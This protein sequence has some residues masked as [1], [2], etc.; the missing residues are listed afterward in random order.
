MKSKNYKPILWL[1]LIVLFAGL[2]SCKKEEHPWSDYLDFPPSFF[3]IGHDSL[4]TLNYSHENQSDTVALKGDVI[5]KAESK[6]DWIS[7]PGSNK[8]HSDLTLR[9]GE[10]KSQ[11]SREGTIILTSTSVDTLPPIAIQVIQGGSAPFM[12]PAKDSVALNS[13]SFTVEVEE[14]IEAYHIKTPW[15]I[16]VSDST[17]VSDFTT[18]YTF[19]VA[20]SYFADRRGAVVF[21]GKGDN[22]DLKDTV[23][24]KQ[25]KTAFPD[26]G[27][28]LP[29]ASLFDVA[30]TADSAKDYSPF[31]FTL[32]NG[33]LPDKPVLSFDSDLNRYVAS[34]DAGKKT[35]F[36]LDYAP[37]GTDFSDKFSDYFTLEVYFKPDL[38][39]T[40]V[41]TV[42]GS[43]KFGGMT[44]EYDKE[45]TLVMK[46]GS[47]DKGYYDYYTI[48]NTKLQ[49]GKYYHV[50]YT[51][52]YSA[53]NAKVYVNGTLEGEVDIDD[54][55][56]RLPYYGDDRWFGFG[57][58]ETA[59]G[60]GENF[61]SGDIVF[62][63][64]YSN[65]KTASD[66]QAM[67]GQIQDRK[68]LTGISDLNDAI[69]NVL[70]QKLADAGEDQKK[71]IQAAIT[72]GWKL[73]DNPGT[74]DEI[75]QTYLNN[76]EVLLNSL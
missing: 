67:Y 74:T 72:V 7:V 47:G 37:K 15:W 39:N 46:L 71:P 40:G 58:D 17:P 9:V 2:F 34:F 41:A 23:I 13:T 44:I 32:T 14:N 55:G 20:A 60:A 35:H 63:R 38:T 4:L 5:Y 45:G 69:V 70:P 75:I 53:K 22:T 18:K 49:A 66:I 42:I 36:K 61:F 31:Q 68:A 6:A 1:S 21:E 59:D 19:D 62:T 8:R 27:A 33:T 12:K 11:D 54:S 56:Y 48:G 64:F 43:L 65:V 73:M 24:I 25:L 76:M 50:V 28:G 3:K 26:A 16:T 30:F 29:V 52:D 51:V 10:N 57:C